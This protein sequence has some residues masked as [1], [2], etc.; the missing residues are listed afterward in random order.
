[1]TIN[2]WRNVQQSMKDKYIV[3]LKNTENNVKLNKKNESNTSLYWRD[4]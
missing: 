3:A 1:M 4:C 2:R